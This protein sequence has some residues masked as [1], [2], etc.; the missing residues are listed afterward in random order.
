VRYQNW[1]NSFI[2]LVLENE[3]GSRHALLAN[4]PVFLAIIRPGDDEESSC[5]D[6]GK[7]L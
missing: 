7:R 3:R 5:W 6:C 2:E 1:E 4:E